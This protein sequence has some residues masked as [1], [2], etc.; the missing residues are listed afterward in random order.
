M[1]DVKTLQADIKTAAQNLAEKTPFP[2]VIVQTN[3]RGKQLVSTAQQKGQDVITGV[4]TQWTSL[5]QERRSQL[6][7]GSISVI[8]ALVVTV[9]TVLAVR[10]FQ[11]RK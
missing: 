2:Q 5:P 3:E 6:M 4:Q 9:A 7:I 10:F 8:T 1:I 11:G